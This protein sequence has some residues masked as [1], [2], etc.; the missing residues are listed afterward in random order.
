VLG[1]VVVVNEAVAAA[2]DCH[3]RARVGSPC[4][5]V[6]VGSRACSALSRRGFGQELKTYLRW[7]AALDT[8]V[9][10][11]G[12]ESG[13]PDRTISDRWIRNRRST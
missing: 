12:V 7:A 13:N 8:T 2:R 11:P 1:E 6:S 3:L 9:K 5:W 4:V 10:A